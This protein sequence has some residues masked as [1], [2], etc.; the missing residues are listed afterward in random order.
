MSDIV[1]VLTVTFHIYVRVCVTSFK[2]VLQSWR[3]ILFHFLGLLFLGIFYSFMGSP[4]IISS[5]IRGLVS[6]YALS[7]YLATVRNLIRRDAFSTKYIFHEALDI[8]SPILSLYFFLMLI[9]FVLRAV[10][11]NFIELAFS[12]IFTV[13]ANPILEILYIRGSNATE[14]LQDSIQFISD[15]FLEWFFPLFCF[16][17][18][19]FGLTPNTLLH[20]FSESP[21]HLFESLLRLLSIQ[22]MNLSVWVYLV[23]FLYLLLFVMVCRG[24]LFLE[25]QTGRRAR[26]YKAKMG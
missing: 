8:F 14:M 13:L 22:A 25:L 23:V 1:R 10:Q 26:M 18:C 11:N 12:I 4:D 16:G 17:I 20:L 9:G 19:V 21:L 2:Q 7:L 3:V 5:L 6:S 24:N 15:N